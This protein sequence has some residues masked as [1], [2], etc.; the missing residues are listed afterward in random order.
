MPQD[1]HHYL[2]DFIATH[3]LPAASVAIWQD[4]QLS[5]AAVGCLN[6]NTGVEATPDS[7]FQIGS[8]T[9]VFTTC[10]V[11]QL[12]DEGKVDLNTP[13]QHYLRDFQIADPEASARITVGQLLNHSNG[14]AGDYFPDDEGH[15]GNLLARYIDRCSFL[16]LVH[17]VGEALCYSN[18]AFAV[19]GR[20]VEVLRGCT[21]FQ[22][23]E[24]Y[25]Y[26]PL[27]LQ[28]AIADPKEGLRFRCAMGHVFGPD[29]SDSHPDWQVP[30]RPYF[31]L[32]QAP[33]GTTPAMSAANLIA[34]ARAHLDG[35]LNQAGERWLSAESVQAMQSPTADWPQTSA[36]KHNAMG[37]GWMIQQYREGDVKVIS[38]SGATNGFLAALHVV[39]ERKAAF[40]ILLNSF[41]GPSFDR[42]QSDLLQRVVGV[43][44][45]EP[46]PAGRL[47]A[48]DCEAL[49]GHYE[50]LDAAIEVFTE[51]DAGKPV[52]KATVTAKIDPVPPQT[53][54]LKRVD[55]DCFATYRKSGERGRN[56]AFQNFDERGRARYLM[57]SL[58]LNERQ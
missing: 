37:L 18:A 23:M 1:L 28:H 21:W 6:L 25:I 53:L 10:L 50:S 30:E 57:S 38:H 42:L 2:Q 24:T 27:G 5:T 26:R 8:I 15:T 52:L 29:A 46:E 54:L 4:G 9:K 58:R 41:K 20:L 17:P 33:A 49:S 7:L 40:A 56:V 16:P 13:V 3:Q 14:I 44:V 55:K 43:S 32:G 47:S 22:A 19:A 51:Q 12:V 45:K 34:F 31:S 39:P 11:M 36:I 35:G 48:A